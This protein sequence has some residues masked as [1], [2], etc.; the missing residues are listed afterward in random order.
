MAAIMQPSA[1]TVLRPA[2]G[3][4]AGDFALEYG[5]KVTTLCGSCCLGGRYCGNLSEA[6]VISNN[7]GGLVNGDIIPIGTHMR[8]F[9][10]DRSAPGAADQGK[11]CCLSIGCL[12]TIANHPVKL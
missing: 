11:D 2:S 10:E 3:A 5:Y 9:L 8:C 12:F 6:A 1:A 4:Y 7:A